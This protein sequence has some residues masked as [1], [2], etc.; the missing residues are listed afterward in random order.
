ML[1]DI[2]LFTAHDRPAYCYLDFRVDRHTAS[3]NRIPAGFVFFRFAADAYKSRQQSERG[4][5]TGYSA[6]SLCV[7]SICIELKWTT[8]D[9][10][11]T[12]I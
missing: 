5:F 11:Y 9:V 4:R 2:I 7:T 6:T 12:P 1:Q 10:G 3:H 8:A